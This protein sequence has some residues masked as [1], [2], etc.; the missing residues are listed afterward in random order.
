MS[1]IILDEDRIRDLPYRK[2]LDACTSIIKNEIDESFRWDAVWL[3]GEIAEL[4]PDTPL[5]DEVA[6]LM[7]WVLKNDSN[8]VVKH[9]ACYQIAARNMRD[10]KSTR[11]NSSHG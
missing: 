9:E 6:N 8:G 2:R 11:L 7:S 4:N 1:K 10:R 3:A 5:F